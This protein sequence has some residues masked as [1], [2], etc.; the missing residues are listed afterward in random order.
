LTRSLLLRVL[1]A[2]VGLL[3]LAAAT[4]QLTGHGYFWTAL[5]HTY[6][7]GHTT[8][9]VDD[10]RNFV[11]AAVAGGEPLAWRRA[12]SQRP[13]SDE[14]REFLTRHRSAAFLVARDGELLHETYFPPYHADSRTNV[15]SMAKTVTTLLYG[16]AVQDGIVPAPDAKAATWLDRYANDAFGREATLLQ[17]AGMSSGHDW[18]ENYYLPFNPTTELYFGGDATATVLRMGFAQPPGKQFYYSSA[19]TQL[20]GIAL[21]RAL[22]RHDP[23]LDLSTYL[24][25]RLWQPLGMEGGASWSLDRARDAGG[26]E[27]AY[28]CIHASARQM[29]RLGQLLLQEGAWQGKQLV[30][31]DFVRQMT[32]PNGLADHYGLGLWMDPGHEPPFHFMQGHLG[33]YVIVLPT[34]RLVVVRLGQYRKKTFSRHPKVPDEVYLYVDEALRMAR[35]AS[36]R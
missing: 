11:Q 3:S 19:S 30:P 29:A 32:Q 14:T 26:I 35:G 12:D 33:Q 4:I 17:L 25:R 31:A 16:A 10:A 18:L 22:A 15:F 24:S 7:Q 6:L 36:A 13:I 9:H 34:E 1:F 27:L 21:A 8:A 20:L 5:R 28:C 2:F 23:S